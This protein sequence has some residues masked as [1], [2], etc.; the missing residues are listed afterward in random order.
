MTTRSVPF[1]ALVF[2]ALGEEDAEDLGAFRSGD[3]DLDDFLR[4][5]ALRLQAAG[6]ARTYLAR[7]QGVLVGFVSVLSDSVILETRERRALALRS[8]DHPVVPALKVGRLAVSDPFRAA[9]RGTGVALVRFA[10][11]LA[12]AMSQKVGCRLLTVD[13]YPA[14]AAFYERLGFVRN[15]AKEYRERARPSMRLDL[16]VQPLPSWARD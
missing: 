16:R 7:D 12:T 1:G 14:S 8:G 11:D 9:N 6:T 10:F 15:R 5:D 3:A 2:H 4:T 13:A